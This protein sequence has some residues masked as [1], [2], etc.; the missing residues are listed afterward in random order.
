MMTGGKAPVGLVDRVGS[1]Q[2]G[3]IMMIMKEEAK[4]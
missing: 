2:V 1:G 3:R 4:E